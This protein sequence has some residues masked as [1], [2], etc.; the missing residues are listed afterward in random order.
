MENKLEKMDI[1]TAMA[2]RHSVRAFDGRPLAAEVQEELLAFIEEANEASGLNIQLV[3]NEPRAFQ[4]LLAH[5][6]KFRGVCN[7]VA[8]VG[9]SGPE[10]AEKCGY[11]GELVVL[12]AQQLGLN[13][14]WVGLTYKKIKGAYQVG[15]GEKLCL[16]IALGYGLGTGA[17]H[18]SKPAGAVMKLHGGLTEPPEWFDRGVQAALLAPT[19]LNQQK[20]CFELMADGRS[21]KS[22]TGR[23]AYTQVDLGIAKLHFELGAG[24]ENF[25]WV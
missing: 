12:L 4:G 19:A 23:G 2:Q 22:T 21:V 5:Y 17:A 1:M 9:R 13:S 14:C 3:V 7:Y 15:P 18:K 20:F 10:L 16:V 8:L 11:W 6:G 25:Y 24:E